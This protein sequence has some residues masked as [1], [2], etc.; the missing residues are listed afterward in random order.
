MLCLVLVL[1]AALS[2]LPAATLAE[3]GQITV[4]APT[5]GLAVRPGASIDVAGTVHT[6]NGTPISGEPVTAQLEDARA[7]VLAE[8]VG[9]T[10][11][12]GGILLTLTIPA[13]TEDGDYVIELESPDPT[14]EPASVHIRVE[15]PF[16]WDEPFLGLPLW[17]WILIVLSIGF[18]SAGATAY[19]KFAGLGHVARCAACRAFVPEDT[20]RCPRCGAE[21]PPKGPPPPGG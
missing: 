16:A 18:A 1:L 15:T 20:V 6:L 19:V 14:I 17:L 21:M 9:V 2:F 12:D 4:I 10:D 11:P 8:A 3:P 7:A 5:D 13:A